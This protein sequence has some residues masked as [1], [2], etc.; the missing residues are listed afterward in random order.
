MAYRNGKLRRG[1]R[2]SMEMTMSYANFKKR[3]LD[4]VGDRRPF[5]T[6]RKVLVGEDKGA[7]LQSSFS[8]VILTQAMYPVN[9]SANTGPSWKAEA[10]PDNV[11]CTVTR[12]WNDTDQCLSGKGKDKLHHILR[13]EHEFALVI[14][15]QHSPAIIP[16]LD[17][18]CITSI[19]MQDLTINQLITHTIWV[20]TNSLLQKPQ[21]LPGPWTPT[22]HSLSYRWL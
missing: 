3:K 21:T 17:G 18:R 19:R 12:S 1:K 14:A 10:E 20:L 7:G 9:L 22:G 5:D 2:K 6:F 8:D 4:K 11:D 15:D 13:K 16:P